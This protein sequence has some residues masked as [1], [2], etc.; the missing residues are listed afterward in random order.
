MVVK[1]I[2][3]IKQREGETTRGFKKASKAAMSETVNAWHDDILPRH[4]RSGAANR[5]GYRKRGLK[6]IKRKQAIVGFNAPLVYT[7]RSRDM[8]KA[9][10]VVTAN[11][12]GARGTMQLPYYWRKGMRGPDKQAELTGI[13]APEIQ[14]LKKIYEKDLQKNIDTSPVKKRR[15]S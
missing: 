11:A 9:N 13:I 14:E 6:Y 1:Q 5:Y 2:V 8:A 4:F 3:F 10:I 15:V 7:G 12:A